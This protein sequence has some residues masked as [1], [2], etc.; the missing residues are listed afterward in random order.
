MY[1]TLHLLA[2]AIDQAGSRLP[3]DIARQLSSLEYW[4]GVAGDRSFGDNGDI[5]AM[6]TVVKRLNRGTFELIRHTF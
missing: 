5:E 2:Y 1:D 3:R 4:E 6:E